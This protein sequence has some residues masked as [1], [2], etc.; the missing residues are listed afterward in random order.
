MNRLEA[1]SRAILVFFFISIPVWI[2]R[3]II[4]A[5]LT[6][7]Y[8]WFRGLVRSYAL[9]IILGGLFLALYY[10][11]QFALINLIF[12][13]GLTFVVIAF[14]FRVMFKGFGGKNKRR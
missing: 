14:G 3:N 8:V 5:G 13:Y 11:K 2:W 12:T 7:V 10:T 1:M 9:W 4:L 6:Q